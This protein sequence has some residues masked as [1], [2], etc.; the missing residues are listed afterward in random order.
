MKK[1]DVVSAI[2][3]RSE[4]F[5]SLSDAIWDSPELAFHET[6]A[7]NLLCDAL[8]KEGFAVTEHLAGIPTAFSGRFGEGGPVIGILGEYDALAGLSQKADVTHPEPIIHGGNGHGCGHNLLGVGSLA[9]AV[10]VKDFLQENHLPGTVIYY[11]CPAEEGGSGKAF[12]ARGGAFDGVDCVL[13]WHPGYLN[14]A[15]A[16]T[17]LA[18]QQMLY[19]FTGISSHAAASPERGRSALDALTLMNTGIQFLREHVPASTRIHYAVLDTGGISPNVVQATASAMYLIRTPSAEDLGPIVERVN[20]VARGAAM[21]TE[22][23]VKIT[24]NKSCANIIPNKPL[25][26]ALSQNLAEMPLPEYTEEELA[27]AK[28]MKDTIPASKDLLTQQAEKFG[29]KLAAFAAQ[30]A[31]APV[32]NFVIPELPITIA[33]S[34]STD[35][36]DVSWVCPTSQVQICTMCANTGSHTWQ[37]TAQGKSPLAHKGMLY[38][39]RVLAGTAIDLLTQPELVAAAHD[40]WEKQLHGRV[41]QPMPAEVV[42]TGLNAVVVEE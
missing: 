19:E 21:M 38:A 36:G 9:A 3:R 5:F 23:D 32:F 1:T 40:E 39:G 13:T 30:H 20:K 41:Y 4:W 35:V 11:G 10:A 17:S 33:T 42:P 22:T 24:F 31:D 15:P 7:A 8:R 12:M 26:N 6:F 2:D 37:R 16:H 29:G 14:A 34:S 18:N 25:S 28:R 27:Y